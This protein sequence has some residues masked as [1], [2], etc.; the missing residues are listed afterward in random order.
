MDKRLLEISTFDGEGY[1]PLIDFNCWRVAFLRY[2][3][4]LEP[5]MIHTV[6]KHLETD[7]VFVLLQGQGIL[8]L[9][10]G[11]QEVEALEA[12]PMQACQLYNVRKDAWHT[13]VLSR[14]ATILL[15]ENRDTCDANSAHCTLN[16]AQR[17]FIQKTAREQMPQWWA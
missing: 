3:D 1:Q 5:P 16:D 14:D 10:S 4:E 7:E 17:Q 13:I 11:D 9:G 15:V 8:F 12:V 6:E 2:I